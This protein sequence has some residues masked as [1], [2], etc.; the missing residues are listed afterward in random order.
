MP[1]FITKVTLVLE[2]YSTDVTW[3]DPP[4]YVTRRISFDVPPTD[5]AFYEAAQERWHTFSEAMWAGGPGF[6]EVEQKA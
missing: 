2:T 5:T 3:G 1:S 4:Q 6:N